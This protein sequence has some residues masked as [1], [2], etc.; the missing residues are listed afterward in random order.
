[1]KERDQESLLMYLET[2]LVDYGG[3]IDPRRVNADDWKQMEEW[4]GDG[5]I[6]FGRLFAAEAMKPN[7]HIPFTHWV[8]FNEEAWLLAPQYRRERAERLTKTVER[9]ELENV[10]EGK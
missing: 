5:L 7:R 8:L 4:E 3:K 2:C 10:K 1:M 6:R 9:N